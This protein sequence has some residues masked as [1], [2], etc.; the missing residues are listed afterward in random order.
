M[1]LPTLAA[2]S[3]SPNYPLVGGVY[4]KEVRMKDATLVQAILDESGSMLSLAPEV[5]RSFDAFVKEQA[6][7]PGEAVLNLLTFNDR[8]TV[9]FENRPFNEVPSLSH[10]YN[11]RSLTA[12]YDALG[13]SIIRVGENLGAM[14]ERERPNKVLFYIYT[15]GLENASK[16]YKDV[17]QLGEMIQHQQNK[18]NW[19][20]LFVGAGLEAFEQADYLNIPQANTMMVDHTDLG[21]AQNMSMTSRAVSNYRSGGEASYDQGNT[22]D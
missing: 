20:F 1:G 12:L 3:P 17:K 21:F 16:D 14:P 18:Y 5:R 7:L 22:K 13:F 10:I 2:T 19:Q 8:Y 6:A 4:T 11:P 9:R 15:D